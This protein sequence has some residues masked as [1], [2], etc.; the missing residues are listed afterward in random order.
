MWYLQH[1]FV[2]KLTFK[3]LSHYDTRIKFDIKIRKKTNLISEPEFETW[4]GCSR[5]WY[6]QSAWWI[7]PWVSVWEDC[8][9]IM[10]HVY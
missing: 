3:W 7:Q 10:M 9:I 6:S 1:V 8:Q 4:L 5:V 2:L